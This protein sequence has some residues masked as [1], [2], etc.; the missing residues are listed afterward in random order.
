VLVG[1]VVTVGAGVEVSV[2]VGADVAD[3]VTVALGVLVSV[4]V[5]GIARKVIGSER[6]SAPSQFTLR[7]TSPTP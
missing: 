5:G 2:A 7:L 6:M 1:T 4:A 3:S